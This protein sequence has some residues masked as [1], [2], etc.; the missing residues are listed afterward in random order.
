M[1]ACRMCPPKAMGI[2]HASYY[3]QNYSVQHNVHMPIKLYSSTCSGSR[4]F[5]RGFYTFNQVMLGI[6]AITKS[7]ASF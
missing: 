2:M 1:L 5:K 6:Y 4:N 3:S 7:H